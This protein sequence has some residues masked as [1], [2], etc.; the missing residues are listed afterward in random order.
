MKR[1]Y[2]SEEMMSDVLMKIMLRSS[3]CC[4]LSAK[5]RASFDELLKSLNV[6]SAADYMKPNPNP[7]HESVFL[8]LTAFYTMIALH[9]FVLYFS[10]RYHFLYH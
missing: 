1:V 3:I 8:F 6:S 9:V 10:L 2:Q 4:P 7:F 5:R